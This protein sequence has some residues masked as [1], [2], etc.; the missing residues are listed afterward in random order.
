MHTV[1]KLHSAI[2]LP[3]SH[4]LTQ[5]FLLLSAPCPVSMHKE[6]GLNTMYT[7]SARRWQDRNHFFGEGGMIQYDISGCVKAPSILG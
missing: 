3:W 7:Y 4:S 1:S 5:L 6:N 2:D